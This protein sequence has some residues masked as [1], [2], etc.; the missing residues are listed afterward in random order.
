MPDKKFNNYKCLI[1]NSKLSAYFKT[2]PVGWV[3]DTHRHLD[4]RAGVPHP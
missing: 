4:R 3:A 1:E 2:L